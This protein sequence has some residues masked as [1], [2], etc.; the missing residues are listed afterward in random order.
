MAA[1]SLRLKASWPG[2]WGPTVA[3]A[4]APPLLGWRALPTP[5]GA[6]AGCRDPSRA[7]RRPFRMLGHRMSGWSRARVQL[8]GRFAVQIDGGRVEDR[9]PGR[10]GRPVLAD[11]V[12]RRGGGGARA[13]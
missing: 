12:G 2:R 13:G 7:F 6:P 11:L 5:I 3:A 10:R 8:C 9:L 1:K 4:M